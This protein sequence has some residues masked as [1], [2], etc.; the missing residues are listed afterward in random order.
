MNGVTN[1]GVQI[2]AAMIELERE[3]VLRKVIFQP[4]LG[5]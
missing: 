5:E 3:N 4:W 1:E 2:A